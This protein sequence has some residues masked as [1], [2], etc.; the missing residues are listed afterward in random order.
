MALK[1]AKKYEGV[2]YRESR[3][4]FFHGRPDRSYT[5]C[6]TH[7]GKKH[8]QTIGWASQGITAEATFTAR[9]DVLR[10]LKI[11]QPV[12]KISNDLTLGQ[13]VKVYLDGIK[14]EGK[15]T[16]TKASHYRHW[17]QPHCGD[18]PL[19]L[20]DHSI[21]TELRAKV[22]A[23][24]YT[25]GSLRCL[26]GTIQAAINYVIRRRLWQ[27][28]NPL[29]PAGGVAMPPKG[30]RCERFLTPDEARQLLDQLHKTTPVWHDM[31]LV[32]LHTGLRLTEIMRLKGQDLD[33]Y[34]GI[35]TVTAKGRGKDREPVALT[36]ES[37]EALA[38]NRRRPD[39]FIFRGP[40][41]SRFRDSE[42]PFT[43]AVRDCGFNE[44]VVGNRHK[45]WFHTL[46]HTFASWLAQSG[47]DLYAIMKLMRHR[48]IEMTQR[49]AHLIPEKQREHL[50]VIRAKFI[51]PE[52][53]G[54]A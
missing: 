35:V 44:G 16:H 20:L 47:V 23:S 4:K 17:I 36:P 24:G 14:T 37:L 21:L 54:L 29:S 39:D 49:Y 50:A 34:S 19:N 13:A 27:G 31:A 32:A 3:K 53:G 9:M 28:I 18:V 8:W 42:G 33:E 41:G 11:G 6:Y 7:K 38:R 40:R 5:F 48:T 26:F 2:F 15:H 45:V 52:S 25:P 43:R 12:V 22:Q 51:S 30:D 46:R 10:R 1:S